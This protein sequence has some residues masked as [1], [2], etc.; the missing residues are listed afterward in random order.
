MDV[1]KKFCI[2]AEIFRIMFKNNKLPAIVW[3]RI[4]DFMHGWVQHDLGGT[5]C[6]KGFKV[7]SVQ[8]LPGAR[9][10][11]MMETAEDVMNQLTVTNSMSSTRRNCIEAGMSLDPEAI[12]QEY[13][14]RKDE[15]KL[16][17][18]IEC[19]KMCLT[20]NGVMRPW[21]LSVNFSSRQATAMQRIIRQAF[22]DAVSEFDKD[23]ARKMDG[24]KYP[25]SE[26]IEAFCAHTG[27]PEL[28]AEAIRREWHRRVKR[29]LSPTLQG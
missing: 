2:F 10:A 1:W 14:I 21:S 27:T 3:L 18:P 28:Y 24:E 8:H 5:F 22:W 17:I 12:V 25:A 15:L 6:V 29:S 9:E 4:T 19:P 23:Y 13:G 16:F 11:L 7:V 26:M 20:T